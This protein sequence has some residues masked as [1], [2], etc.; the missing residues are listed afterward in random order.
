MHID[1]H[2]RMMANVASKAGCKLGSCICANP[3]AC[4]A[5]LDWAGFLA[6]QAWLAG[7]I[8]SSLVHPF[9]MAYTVWLMAC[10]EFFPASA[11]LDRDDDRRAQSRRALHGLCR[12]CARR[13]G[14][15]GR[16]ARPAFAAM[17]R[18]L[19]PHL[20][21]LDFGG[22]L[23]RALAIHPQP[24]RLEQ[25]PA[26]TRAAAEAGR[27]G[28]GDVLSHQLLSYASCDNGSST[29]NIGRRRDGID[30]ASN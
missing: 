15:A 16:T 19:T 25:N 21:A 23:A 29:L 22:R 28:L 18:C 5:N 2:G 7:L 12:L 13:L 1:E 3:A 17:A 6:T 9:F 14:G 8:F 11:D 10:G 4:F 26:W 27:K 20:L 24:F 30:D